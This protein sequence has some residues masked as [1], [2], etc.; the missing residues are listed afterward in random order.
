MN[1]LYTTPPPKKKIDYVLV[2][3]FASRGRWSFLYLIIS[4]LLNTFN[5]SLY[6]ASGLAG[7]SLFLSFLL[8]NYLGF[9]YL[10][11]IFLGTCI[12]IYI[13]IYISASVV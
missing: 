11:F 10:Q 6:L 4:F 9:P 8:K 12:Y 5:A 13:Y 2:F 1:S 3:T 7:Q